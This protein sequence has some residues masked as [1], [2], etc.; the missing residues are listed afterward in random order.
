M[1]SQIHSQAWNG[2]V[3][4]QSPQQLPQ[5]AQS[6]HPIFPWLQSALASPL[7]EQSVQGNY[8]VFHRHQ[9]ESSMQESMTNIFSPSAVELAAFNVEQIFALILT[10]LSQSSPPPQQQSFYRDVPCPILQ[11]KQLPH[12]PQPQNHPPDLRQHREQ[13][14]NARQMQL[15]A[16]SET[17]PIIKVIL[18]LLHLT[19]PRES[20]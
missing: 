2:I 9:Q 7:P 17:T 18:Q 20:S 11:S 4:Q 14:P 16:P 10:L 19:A 15:S 5:M 6:R 1:P 12:L 3:Q 13:P 8:G